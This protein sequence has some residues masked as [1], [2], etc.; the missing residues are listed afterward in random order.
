MIILETNNLKKY[1]GEGESLV[2]A[3]DGVDLQVEQG[4]LSLSWEPAGAASPHFCICWA[5]WIIPPGEAFWW[6]AG[7]FLL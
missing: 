2:K 5:D 4:S 1:Y 7:T 3:L 6:T